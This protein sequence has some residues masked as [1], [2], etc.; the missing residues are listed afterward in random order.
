MLGRGDV[1]PRTDAGGDPAIK[2]LAA[3]A[4]KPWRGTGRR[5]KVT[6]RPGR[7]RRARQRPPS[8][9]PTRS[10]TRW[11]AT[12]AP[13]RNPQPSSPSWRRGGWTAWEKARSR[14]PSKLEKKV[15]RG[16]ILRRAAHRRPRYPHRASHHH[17][18]GVL[19]RTHGSALFTRGETQAMVVTTLAPPAMPR[20]SMPSRVS[21]KS[22]HAA[23]QLPALLCR[24]DRHVGSPKRREIGHGRLAKRGVQAV[25]PSPMISPTP[26]AWCPR[27]PNPTA[28][29]PW[30]ASAAAAWR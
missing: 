7:R 5:R 9:R 15:V 25:M 13:Q 16:R 21:A 29:A 18:V 1:R 12:A 2:E 20:S 30:P 19:P 6:T 4:G 17:Q 8:P 27:S 10:A 23:L 22:L 26:C 28:P 11:P 14:R 24:R 3:E